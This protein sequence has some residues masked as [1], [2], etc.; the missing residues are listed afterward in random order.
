MSLQKLN[1]EDST[2]SLAAHPNTWPPPSPVDKFFLMS[3]LNLQDELEAVSSFSATYHLRKETDTL[4]AAA[5]F[6]VVVNNL[7][8]YCFML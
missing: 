3:N 4:L 2:T 1:G 8:E 5:F 6:P 7:G